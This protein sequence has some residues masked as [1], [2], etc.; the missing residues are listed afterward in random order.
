MDNMRQQTSR[1]EMANTISHAVAAILAVAA[2][3]F[4]VIAAV[5]NGSPAVVVGVSV[6]SFT[7]VVLYATSSIYHAL[8][9][10]RWKKLFQVLDHSAIYLLIAGSYTPF[11]RSV[12]RGTLGWTL[13]GVVWGL[14]LI[15]ILLKNVGS[16]RSPRL[17]VFLY[18][19]M[20]WLVVVAI[21]PLWSAMPAWGFWCLVGGGLSYTFGVAF[22]AAH[23]VRYAHFVWH[24]FVMIGTGSHVAAVWSVVHA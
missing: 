23:K 8:P 6:F 19:L 9:N 7:M 22:F 14:A 13:L 18:V 12:L 11:T 3:P 16:L 4:L 20:G 1:E 5:D 24:L 2:V 15:G 10:N 17:S 21:K